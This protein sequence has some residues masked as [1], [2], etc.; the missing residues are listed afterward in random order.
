MKNLI[1]K[2]KY[3]YYTYYNNKMNFNK[4]KSLKICFKKNSTL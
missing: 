4:I 3:C 1:L 2:K